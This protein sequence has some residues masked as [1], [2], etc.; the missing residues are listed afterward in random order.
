MCHRFWQSKITEF[1]CKHI[2]SA[3][4][5][6]RIVL[7]VVVCTLNRQPW[8]ASESLGMNTFSWHF[9]Q[10]KHLKC[11]YFCWLVVAHCKYCPLEFFY[12]TN[13]R[14]NLTISNLFLI[15][16]LDTKIFLFFL[17]NQTFYCCFWALRL[18]HQDCIKRS[19]LAWFLSIRGQK[20]WLQTVDLDSLLGL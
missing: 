14:K 11:I 17:D 13:T 10:K 1:I 20:N 12:G 19:P 5:S 18:S 7:S 8:D 15:I 4:S 6:K 2:K 16:Y 3:L 9:S